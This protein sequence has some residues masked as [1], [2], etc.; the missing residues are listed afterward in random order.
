MT[1]GEMPRRGTLIVVAVVSL[2]A[3]AFANRGFSISQTTSSQENVQTLKDAKLAWQECNT[4]SFGGYG[5]SVFRSKVP[6][7]WFVVIKQEHPQ[8][9]SPS[10]TFYP[11]PNHIWNGTS[12]E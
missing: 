1:R 9:I 10:L 11:D 2:L 6:G 12:L 5:Q 3:F 4:E 7:G 8:P